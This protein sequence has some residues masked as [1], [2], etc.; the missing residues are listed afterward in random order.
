M[1]AQKLPLEDFSLL[2]CSRAAPTLRA[3]CL[4]A[5]RG[6][7]GGENP[8]SALRSSP[9]TLCYNPGA[10]GKSHLPGDLERATGKFSPRPLLA[11][12]CRLQL[13]C[14]QCWGNTSCLFFLIK[15]IK[16]LQSN[17]RWIV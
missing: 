11:Q 3:G 17:A 4:P 10:V 13:R 12:W 14:F 1:G 9:T 15:A 8:S 5:P 6:T 16:L 7:V 2:S